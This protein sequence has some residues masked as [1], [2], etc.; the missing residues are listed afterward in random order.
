MRRGTISVG[1]P[2]FLVQSTVIQQTVHKPTVFE[3]MVL[4]LCGKHRDV[5]EIGGL[6]LREIFEQKL[7][8]PSAPELVGPSVDS[9]V[10]LGLLQTPLGGNAFE[11]SLAQL[12]LTQEG[13]AILENGRFPSRS[14][15]EKVEHILFPLSGDV[16]LPR[17]RDSYQESPVAPSVESALLWPAN[18]SDLVRHALVSDATEAAST[19]TELLSIDSVNAGTLW[20]FHRL[21]LDCDKSARLTIS[22]PEA[23][24][25]QRWLDAAVPETVWD[26]IL[27]PVLNGDARESTWLQLDHEVVADADT[28]IP[29]FVG[30]SVEASLALS[31]SPAL[32][33]ICSDTDALDG[34]AVPVVMLRDGLK[35]ARLVE[36][37]DSS[38]RVEVPWPINLPVG[39]N[40]LVLGSD[41]VPSAMLLGQCR[42]YWA[43]QPRSCLASVTLNS[44]ASARVWNIVRQAMDE[45]LSESWDPVLA[46]L[47]ILWES[48]ESAIGRWIAQTKGWPLPAIVVEAAAFEEGLAR[49]DPRPN[50]EWRSAWRKALSALLDSVSN[51]SRPTLTATEYLELLLHGDVGPA[52]NRPIVL[53]ELFARVEPV[54]DLVELGELRQKLGS[55]V[56]LPHRVIGTQILAAWID[57]TLANEAPMLHGPH[58]FVEPIQ[59]L[60]VAFR[61]LVREID[62]SGTSRSDGRLAKDSPPLASAFVSV[63]RWH[64]AVHAIRTLLPMGMSPIAALDNVE[65]SLNKWFEWIRP[66][67]APA[68]PQGQRFVVFD[69]N[70]LVDRPEIISGVRDGD[71]PV[72][73]KRVLEELDGLKQSSDAAIAMAARTAIRVLGQAEDHVNYEP[74]ATHLLPREFDPRDSDNRIL[75]VA[76]WLR[77]SRVVLVT[78]DNDLR[79]KARA[80]HIDA[81][82]PEDYTGGPAIDGE[83][84]SAGGSLS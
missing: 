34:G 75:S 73:P 81:M 29:V 46:G 31:E 18:C 41:R 2:V 5:A 25:V 49:S 57:Q 12:S 19:D 67:F 59:A 20:E 21:A 60:A 37:T 22:A 61:E 76:L 14:R 6:S 17:Q 26:S 74:E 28:I 77:L 9:L 3:R 40:C 80:E 55:I 8:V 1:F 69:T 66:A 83:I 62:L 84:A 54:N 79:L 43:G 4:R 39:F 48:P 56:E 58:A 15:P 82:S 35:H 52:V 72:I 70:T 33:V 24:E 16:R 30:S 50:A 44:T 13:R 36:G 63:D 11:T 38:F 45:D 78:A 65:R 47:R 71:V 23:P 7:G 42:V 68:R 32:R 27:E 51:Q 53:Q 10:A 64:L